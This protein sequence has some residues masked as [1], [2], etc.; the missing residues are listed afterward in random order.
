MATHNNIS[1]FSAADIEKYHQGLL[2]NAERHA[3]EKA[4][5][6]DPFLADAMEGYAIAGVQAQ[7]DIALL[8]KR[9]AEKTSTE[10]SKVVSMTGGRKNGFPWFRA[11]A[12]VLIIGGA[13]LLANQFLF[14]K[15]K[16]EIAQV[17]PATVTTKATDTVVTEKAS[18]GATA[19]IPVENAPTT[20][21]TITINTNKD[22]PAGESKPVPV[23]TGGN[24]NTKGLDMS[25][26]DN[27]VTSRPAA[28][29]AAEPGRQFDAEKVDDAVAKR[30]VENKAAVQQDMA[31][32]KKIQANKDFAAANR[33]KEEVEAS[34]FKKVNNNN[35]A[36]SRKADE[37]YYRNQ[38]NN[39][40]RG[41]VTDANN[42][43]IPF[44]N[45]T[46]VED[47][48]GTYADADGFFNLTSPDSVLTVQIRSIG[49]ENNQTQLRN[50]APTNQVVLRDDRRSLSETVI[51]NQKPN[52]AARN[53]DLNKTLQE[54]EPAD[55]W[56]NYDTY[57]ANNLEVPDDLKS[58][59]NNAGSVQLSFE[60]DKNGEPVNIKVEK[61]L[62]SKCDKEA[63]RLVKDG[64]KWKRAA[65][66]KGRT[67]VTI[68]F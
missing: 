29:V 14:N 7:K 2:S 47:K 39:V 43:G 51:S 30:N 42:V 13:G 64:P 4:A 19:V 60:V 49:F 55:G 6:E 45:V 65:S 48:A 5:L 22:N 3:M 68:N 27:G 62:C 66:K 32:A 16:E 1:S 20:K 28:P 34:N 24:S 40:F 11:A 41:R 25:I 54:P 52:A 57:L 44:A 36:A 59:Q 53:R 21:N 23:V 31:D 8:K 58:K 9:L 18:T 46:N 56:D 63:I 12:A 10:E 50:A 26:P 15:E 37:Q 35:V 17:K 38:T 67:T 61:S 33:A